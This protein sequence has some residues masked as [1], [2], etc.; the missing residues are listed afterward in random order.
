MEFGT[1]TL[2][3]KLTRVDN[4]HEWSPTILRMV[5]HQPKDGHPPTLGWSPTRRKCTTD[6]KFGTYTLLTKMRLGENCHGWSPTNP[7]I[8]THQPKDVHH[9]PKD[10]HPPEGN[11]LQTSNWALKHYLQNYHQVTTAMHSHLLSLWWSPTNPRMV[12][13]QKEV[14][15]RLKIWQ[16]N[17]THR[18]TSSD[19][20]H[21]WSPTILRRVTRQPWDG[22]PPIQEWSPCLAPFDTTWP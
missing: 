2:L 14:Y 7:R 21:G 19:S 16:L 15:Y 3:T 11:V 4:C 8:V 22:H 9:Q 10:G 18:K 6:F 5:V 20:C 17:L 1:Y 13:H 12:T